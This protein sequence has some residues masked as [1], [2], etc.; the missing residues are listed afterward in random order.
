MIYKPVCIAS[1]AALL[2]SVGAAAHD[3]DSHETTLSPDER[4]ELEARLE[5]KRARLRE[6]A[7]E[8]GELS[9]QLSEGPIN[10]LVERIRIEH[11]RAFLGVSI[12]ARNDE[13]GVRVQGVTPDG[14]AEQAGIEAGDVIVAIGGA[15]L[16]D[17]ESSEAVSRLMEVLHD[18]EAGDAVSVTVER[19]G[20]RRD[21][22]VVTETMAD[23]ASAFAFST[24]PD[25]DFDFRF[26]T[27][28]S[29]FVDVEEFENLGATIGENFSF[30]WHSGPWSDMELVELT[31]E[32]GAYF[33]VDEGLL[34]VRAPSDNELGL[35]D[36]D[37]IVE[38]NDE[39]VS[40]P[41]AF[42]RS[43][44]RSKAGD[45]VALDIVRQRG[46]MTLEAQVPEPDR[47]ASVF[48]S[49]DGDKVIIKRRFADRD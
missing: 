8:M 36:G 37:V 38:L 26:D 43:L 15:D 29:D 11:D 7:E 32:L 3:D 5:E 41:R 44:G 12:E 20:R 6:L 39:P 25:M 14:P 49:Q 18:V 45:R 1:L 16:S 27:D 10:R 22:D 24:H 46:A 17:V 28:V 9:V 40:T 13:T 2:F 4:V 35:V 33:G 31:P 42:T 48:R 34:V 47:D 21:F 19:D 23:H 30:I